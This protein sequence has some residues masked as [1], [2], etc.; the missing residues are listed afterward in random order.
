MRPTE[1]CRSLQQQSRHSTF[2]LISEQILALLTGKK[3]MPPKKT[4]EE[5][6]LPKSEVHSSQLTRKTVLEPGVF[7]H[8]SPD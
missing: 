8:P 6:R 5:Q 1:F 4:F 7:K 3:K 2:N